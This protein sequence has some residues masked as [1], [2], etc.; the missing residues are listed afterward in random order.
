MNMRAIILMLVIFSSSLSG[1]I[2]GNDSDE[3]NSLLNQT[4][5]NEEKGDC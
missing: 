3:V 4:Q 1:C 5:L 2:S